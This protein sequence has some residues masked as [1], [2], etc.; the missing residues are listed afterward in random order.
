MKRLPMRTQ[1][2][3]AAPGGARREQDVADIVRL[4]RRRPRVGRVGVAAARNEVVPWQVGRF[5]PFERHP[6]DVPERRQGGAIEV[7]HL[8]GAEKLS[9]RHQQRCAGAGQ[10]VGGLAG[11]ISSVQ[12]NHRGAGAVGG[13]AGHHPVPAVRRPERDPIATANA[14]VNHRGGGPTHLVAQ[15]TEG[16]ALVVGDQ[17][18]VVGKLTGNPVQ[19]RGHGAGIARH[20]CSS[21]K[22]SAW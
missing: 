16:Q 22:A 5:V 1:H 11:G 2:A 6:D 12:R 17:R 13:Q 10:D 18:I 4:D 9:H 19:H 14:E 20:R 3:F 21:N 8:V 15:L 7:G